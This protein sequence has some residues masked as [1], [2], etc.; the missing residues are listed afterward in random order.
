MINTC[1]LCGRRDDAKFAAERLASSSW[2]P[3]T[4]GAIGSDLRWNS[5]TAAD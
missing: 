5:A 1:G 3:D 2:S 4:N